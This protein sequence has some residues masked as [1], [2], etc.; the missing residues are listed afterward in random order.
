MEKMLPETI[1]QAEEVSSLSFNVIKLEFLYPFKLANW[2]PFRK[3]LSRQLPRIDWSD[4]YSS[5]SVESLF[6]QRIYED[7]CQRPQAPAVDSLLTS[8][9]HDYDKTGTRPYYIKDRPFIVFCLKGANLTISNPEALPDMRQRFSESSLRVRP[10]IRLQHNGFGIVKIK[11]QVATMEGLRRLIT[12][13]IYSANVGSM[14]SCERIIACV[15]AELATAIRE[16]STVPLGCLDEIP[17]GAGKHAL[18]GALVKLVQQVNL[19][20][21]SLSLRQVVDLQNLDRGSGWGAEPIT[22]WAGAEDDREPHLYHYFHHLLDDK[23]VHWLATA[24]SSQADFARF[25]E[26]ESAQHIRHKVRWHAPEGEHPYVVTLAPAPYAADIEHSATLADAT[27]HFARQVA[28]SH[29]QVAQLIMKSKWE[30]MRSDWKPMREALENVFYSDL[31]YMAIHLRGSLCL[32]YLPT[33]P[34]I[35]YLRSPEL[36]TIG[37]YRR[38]LRNTIEDQRLL[39]YMYSLYNNLVGKEMSEIAHKF[40]ELM[41]TSRQEDFPR[42]FDMLADITK[43]IENRKVAAAEVMEDPQSRRGGSTLFTEM[44][45]KSTHAFRLEQLYRNLRDK[46]ERLDMLGIHINES[47]HE[48]TA[49]LVDESSRGAQITLE[50]LES[51]LLGVYFA[52]LT[53][54]AVNVYKEHHGGFP[55]L[56]NYWG[57]FYVIGLGAFMTAL[58]WVTMLRKYRTRM[59]VVEPEWQEHVEAIFAVVGP[60]MLAVLFFSFFQGLHLSPVNLRAMFAAA[61]GGFLPI[62]FW[63]RL[64]RAYKRKFAFFTDRVIVPSR[65][66]RRSLYN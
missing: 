27:D 26:K 43:K 8:G 33:N 10:T 14:S 45:D 53:D 44:L 20:D 55:F 62:Y 39:W 15:M 2:H 49:L 34:E 41:D 60:A 32:Y 48:F 36:L 56:L 31:I 54:F 63:F 59:P 18:T 61:L 4:E 65:A 29:K 52:D 57:A 40:D 21:E 28:A 19:V 46:L 13:K 42:M 11:L 64:R 51:V 30:Q 50:I 3:T 7:L 66:L 37:K 38:E 47:V 22:R 12:E 35:E 24:Y 58:P 23:L 17:E 25:F 9:C 6:C 1:L 16:R 5:R